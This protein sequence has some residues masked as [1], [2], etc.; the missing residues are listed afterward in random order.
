MLTFQTHH[1]AAKS[2]SSVKRAMRFLPVLLIRI[3]IGPSSSLTSL[4]MVPE[5]E[6]SLRKEA[7]AD[8]YSI[9]RANLPLA[10]SRDLMSIEVKICSGLARGVHLSLADPPTPNFE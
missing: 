2:F 9:G 1:Q 4:T 5:G 6:R 3:S 8:I 10:C 7:I